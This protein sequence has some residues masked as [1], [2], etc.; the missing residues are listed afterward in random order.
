MWWFQFI[1]DFLIYLLDISIDS[2]IFLSKFSLNSLLVLSYSLI[3]FWISLNSLLILSW[4]YFGALLLTYF[5]TS[6]LDFSQV[7]LMI[8]PWNIFLNL[9]F[10]WFSWRKACPICQLQLIPTI[11]HQFS[12]SFNFLIHVS[13]KNLSPLFIASDKKK[14]VVIV[15]F[16]HL[17]QWKIYV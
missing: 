2:F 11:L 17:K 12:Y 5:L 4:F 13:K 7:S 8:L 6:L 1:L 3:L 16:F 10:F 14:L 15:R 9:Q